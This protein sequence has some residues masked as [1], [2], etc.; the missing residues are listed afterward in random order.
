MF[1][2]FKSIFA[3]PNKNVS[4]RSRLVTKDVWPCVVYAIG[5]VHGSL[6]ELEALEGMIVADAQ[7]FA[8]PKLIVMLGDY[9]DRGPHSAEV[10]THLLAPPPASFER[11]CLAGNHDILMLEKLDDPKRI[12]DWLA[13]GGVETLQ[14]YGIDLKALLNA[15]VDKR[16]RLLAEAVPGDHWDFLRSLPLMLSMPGAV[17]VHAG[18]RRGIPLE[19]QSER[20]L[21]WRRPVPEMNG[22]EGDDLIV[23]GHTPVD[24]PEILPRR[25]NI[26]TAAFAT[27]ILTALRITP[28]GHW[29][30]LATP[31]H[32]ERID[33]GDDWPHVN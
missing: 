18:I 19:A 24:E 28:D 29:K 12:E 30:I 7:E 17:F 26:D 2:A 27:G 10:L 5:D 1:D 31:P 9:M 14:S 32:G 6:A 22:G 8:E 13:I 11:V 23:H 21:V 15:P 16:R 20:D 25:A 3:G 33:T 4:E